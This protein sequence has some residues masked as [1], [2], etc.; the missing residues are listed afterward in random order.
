MARLQGFFKN[1]IFSQILSGTSICAMHADDT[2][3]HGPFNN[4]QDGDKLQKDLDALVDWA[5]TWQLRFNADKCKV[6]HMGKNNEQCCY[7]M[8][9]HGSSDRVTLEK[10]ERERALGVQVNN[11]LRFSQHIEHRSTNLTGCWV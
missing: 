6:H 9:K 10:S 3:I 7:K 8:R 2:K 1:H 5:D 11:D 4:S